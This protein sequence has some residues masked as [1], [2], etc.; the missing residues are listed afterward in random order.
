MNSKKMNL[1]G[2]DDVKMK[3]KRKI[4]KQKWNQIEKRRSNIWEKASLQLTKVYSHGID[5]GGAVS[6]CRW[7]T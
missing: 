6:S 7:C 3:T 4:S 5:D 1:P 2:G